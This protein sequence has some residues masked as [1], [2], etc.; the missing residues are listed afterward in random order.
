VVGRRKIL[1]LA[2]RLRKF[3][4]FCVAGA[5]EI[6]SLELNVTRVDAGYITAVVMLKLKRRR[7][8]NGSVKSVDKRDTAARGKLQNI[9][10]QIDDLTTKSNALEEQ[11]RLAKTGR[12]FGRRDT[13]WGDGKGGECLVL[14]ES[15]IRNVGIKYSDMKV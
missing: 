5:I 11:L 3:V 7:A 1:D 2:E 10:L 13:V 15:I 6:S 12:E 8:G 14:G 4:T 9:L